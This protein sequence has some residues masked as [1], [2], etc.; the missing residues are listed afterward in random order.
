MASFSKLLNSDGTLSLIR[1]A[2]M[3]FRGWL[4]YSCI[5]Q[6][7]Y[8]HHAQKLFTK[9]LF[10]L[11]WLEE[12]HLIFFFLFIW[13]CFIFIFCC[14]TKLCTHVGKYWVSVSVT[15]LTEEISWWTAPWAEITST[16]AVLRI[17]FARD[18]FLSRHSDLA[19][20]IKIYVYI[21]SGFSPLLQSYACSLGRTIFSHVQARTTDRFEA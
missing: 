12:N 1:V 4:Q 7:E 14:S 11:Y 2:L 17:L 16:R 13:V 19:M 15:K 18:L 9:R 3:T 8:S 5:F 6:L 10:V 21:Q 20:Y